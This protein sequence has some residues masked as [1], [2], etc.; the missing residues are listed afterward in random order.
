MGIKSNSPWS[1]GARRFPCSNIAAIFLLTWPLSK[2][3]GQATSQSNPK[4]HAEFPV[5][6]PPKIS[7][8]T[9]LMVHNTSV[10][11]WVPRIWL[12]IKLYSS[13]YFTSIFSSTRLRLLGNAVI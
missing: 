4:Q 12:L 1:S 7:I 8:K 13:A 2:N 6:F 11:V 5:P 10:R 3:S 9:L